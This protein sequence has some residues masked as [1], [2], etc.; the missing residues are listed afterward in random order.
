M[1]KDSTSHQK[2]DILH[3]NTHWM[4]PCA[5]YRTWWHPSITSLP[6]SICERYHKGRRLETIGDSGLQIHSIYRWV[7]VRHITRPQ[8]ATWKVFLCHP[9]RSKCRSFGHFSTAW[10]L[11]RRVYRVKLSSPRYLFSTGCTRQDAGELVVVTI[12][13]AAADRLYYIG[14]GGE[15]RQSVRITMGVYIG[16]AAWYS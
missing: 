5:F 14:K 11:Y 2:C 15:R 1:Q 3:L 4:L 6:Q 7:P 16:R 10:W 8:T 12:S 13:P 9:C